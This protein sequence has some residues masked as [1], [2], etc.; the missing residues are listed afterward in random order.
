[1]HDFEKPMTGSATV[2]LRDLPPLTLT[3]QAVKCPK[4]GTALTPP[5]PLQGIDAVVQLLCVCG[6][7]VWDSRVGPIG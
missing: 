2:V 7:P 5:A 4:C 1:M 3:V 6:R